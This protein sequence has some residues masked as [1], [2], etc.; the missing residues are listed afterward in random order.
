MTDFS[1]MM[2]FTGKRV[3][4]TGGTRGIGRAVSLAFAARGA[5]VAMSFL[6]NAEAA[7]RALNEM[8][9]GRLRIEMGAALRVIRR[10][11]EG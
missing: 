7:Q 10:A 3:L 8:S 5:R 6:S 11:K 4:V 2:D 9:G 1:K